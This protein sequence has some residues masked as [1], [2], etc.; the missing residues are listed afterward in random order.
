MNEGL[1][2]S[3][4][5]CKA[6]CCKH[7]P[8]PYQPLAPEEY[9]ENFGTSDAYNTRCMALDDEGKC[10]IWGTP[11]FP[12]V[13]RTHVCNQRIFS[14]EELKAIDEVEDMEC[15]NCSAEWT[16]GYFKDNKFHRECEVCGHLQSWKK[17]VVKR[18][19]KSL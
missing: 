9:L 5:E 2:S 10:S 15:D 16:R 18:G 7:G 17:E 19:K 13:C 1:V 6:I 12:H 8:G 4:F 14:K 11:K 3:C